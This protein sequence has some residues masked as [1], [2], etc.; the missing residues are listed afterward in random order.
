MTGKEATSQHNKVAE[1]KNWFN[2]FIG[3]LRTDEAMLEIGAINPEK[4]KFYDDIISGNF[5][6]ILFD[7]RE[8]VSMALIAQ[9]VKE[10]LKILFEEKK[11]SPEKIAFEL[12]NYKVL[13]WVVIDMDDNLFERELVVTEALINAKYSKYGLHI[14]TTIVEK[15][16]NLPVPLHYQ[17]LNG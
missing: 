5:Q 1:R 10:Y 15:Q 12:S 6:E 13:V 8:K 17:E 11:V 16:D 14:S 3:E 7:H 2:E 4:E 9:M